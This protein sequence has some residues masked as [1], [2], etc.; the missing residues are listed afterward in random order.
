MYQLA[1]FNTIA[2]ATPEP[3]TPDVD[4]DVAEEEETRDKVD[5][6]W[7]VILYNDDVH[8]FEEVILQLMKA[9]GCSQSQAEK[10]AWTAH[11]KGKDVVFRGTFDECF[12]VQGVLQEI[13]LVTEIRG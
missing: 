8:S 6:P 9:T 5:D 3:A 4:V 11:T 13:Q 2:Q 12:R 10:H 7:V 1:P